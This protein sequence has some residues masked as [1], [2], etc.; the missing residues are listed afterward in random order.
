MDAPIALSLL[1]EDIR[2]LCGKD[3][4]RPL[5]VF[6]V[7]VKPLLRSR[8]QKGLQFFEIVR[9]GKISCPYYQK[10]FLPSGTS[11]SRDVHL[12]AGGPRKAAMDVQIRQIDL[13]KAFARKGL[14]RH[15]LLRTH[16]L[17]GLALDA[18]ERQNLG[19]FAG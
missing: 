9:M 6:P 19:Y 8:F 18:P 12:L 10:P 5:W 15:S 17:Q 2:D 4:T 11:Q 7:D 1:A 3:K 16:I 13:C 14:H